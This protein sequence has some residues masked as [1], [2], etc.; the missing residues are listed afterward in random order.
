[1]AVALI[2]AAGRGERLGAEGPKAFIALAGKPMLQWSVEAFRAAGVD[3]VVVAVP[4]GWEPSSEAEAEAL[5]GCTVCHGGAER[6]H[7]VR[8]ALLAAGNIGPDEA[9]LVHDAARPL[10]TPS[11]IKDL[12]QAVAL[13]SG[14]E[15]AIAATSVTDTIKVND[16]NGNVASTLDRSILRAVQTPQ[17][18]RASV[19][20]AALGQDEVTLG[21]ATDDAALVEAMGVPVRLVDAPSTNFKVTEPKDLQLAELLLAEKVGS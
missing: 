1:V 2:V 21:K 17:A 18:F 5:T 11:L 14:G 13:D 7:S 20:Q 9:V 3:Q 19:L 10:V 6:S 8:N 16:G 15:A 4:S 12:V